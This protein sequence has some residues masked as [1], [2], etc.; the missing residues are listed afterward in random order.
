MK[1]GWKCTVKWR[2]LNIPVLS[3]KLSED[4]WT[5]ELY[6]VDFVDKV[7]F[8]HYLLCFKWANEFGYMEDGTH[9]S[10]NQAVTAKTDT[11]LSEY[12]LREKEIPKGNTDVD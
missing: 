3:V 5:S 8:S 12:K 1:A 7:D 4:T 10:E 6:Q 9:V 11:T 2:N